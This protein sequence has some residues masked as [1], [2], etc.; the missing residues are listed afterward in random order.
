M[1]GNL[2]AQSNIIVFLYRSRLT[3]F[4]NENDSIGSKLVVV[5]SRIGISNFMMGRLINDS[6]NNSASTTITTNTKWTFDDGGF[7]VFIGFCF[8]WWHIEKSFMR[9][10]ITCHLF[11]PYLM[12]KTISQHYQTHCGLRENFIFLLHCK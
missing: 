1:L 4:T 2:S 12:V 9:I 3:F 10:M 7:V 5:C 11:S 8:C 6:Q